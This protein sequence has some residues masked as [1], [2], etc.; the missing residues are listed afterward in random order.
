MELE[1]RIAV[2][3]GGGHGIGQQIAL[4]LDFKITS[5]MSYFYA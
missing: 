1:N 4:R 2:V 3:T 5:D